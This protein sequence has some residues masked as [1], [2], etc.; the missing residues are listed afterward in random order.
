ML[1]YMLIRYRASIQSRGYEPPNI[2]GSVIN[3]NDLRRNSCIDYHF[4]FNR[5]G[6]KQK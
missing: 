1:G 2:K 4:P 6:S 5:F 3:R